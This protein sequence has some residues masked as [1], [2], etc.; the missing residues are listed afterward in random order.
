MKLLKKMS[1]LLV[2]VVMMAVT[3]VPAFAADVTIENPAN[4]NANITNRTFV[5][6]QIFKGREAIVDGKE[7]LGDIEWGNA[8]NNDAKGAFLD[9]LKTSVF[10]DNFPTNITVNDAAEIAEKIATANDAQAIQ[11]ARVAYD[12]LKTTG[13][14]PEKYTL[15]TPT[16]TDLPDGYYLIVDE[17]ENLGEGQA[18]NPALLEVVGAVTITPK[19]KDVTV[20]KQVKDNGEN[21]GYG[22]SADYSIGDNVPFRLFAQVPSMNHYDKY[23]F[24]FH[25]TL[26]NGLTFNNDSVKVYAV[27]AKTV[28]NEITYDENQINED[29]LILN[30]FYNIVYPGVEGE[31]PGNTNNQ[32]FSVEFND[33]KTVEKVTAGKYIV[34]EYTA[35][36]NSDATIGNI[37]NTNE[38]ILEYSNNPNAGG[39]GNT[40]KKEVYVYT[41]TLNGEKRDGSNADTKLSNAKFII[42][43]TVNDQAQYANVGSNGKII[44]TTDAEGKVIPEWIDWDGTF[45]AAKA[46][47]ENGNI[48]SGQDGNFKIEGL[49]AGTY[50]LWETQAPEGYNTPTVPFIVTLTADHT[51]DSVTTNVIS[52][53]QTSDAPN[54][55]DNKETTNGQVKIDIANNKG[56]TLPET[57]GMGT[58]LLYVAGGILLIGSAVLLVTKKRMGHEN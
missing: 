56:T 38:V 7:T 22:E 19:T 17:T 3:V 10:K 53:K 46:I 28:E 20:G 1:A 54:F 14:V 2:A 21:E 57:G 6:Y 29:N 43:R 49:D 35:K 48:V 39:T 50:E 9:S 4:G 25:D 23:E 11:I 37:P 40:D 32:K 51:K 24:K 44:T 26:S 45:E 8:F 30:T 15:S 16:T 41:F 52:Y 31:E 36:L 55:E 18:T 42:S 13:N 5:A 58:T 33:L 12:A 27:E 47:G 34:I